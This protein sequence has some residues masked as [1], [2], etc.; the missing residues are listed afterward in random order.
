MAQ[1]RCFRLLAALACCALLCACGESLQ[2]SLWPGGLWPG[3]LLPS[4]NV[5]ELL[6]APRQSEQQNAVQTALNNYLGESLQ[7]KYPRGG[8]EPDPVIFADLD[9][10]GAGEAAV[11]YTAPSKGQNVHL[12]VLE[13]GEDGWSVAYEVM[14]L[15]S[16]VAEV[17]RVQLFDGSV[18]L[19]VGYANANL[20][21]KYLEIYDY[22]D[23]TIYSA[24]RQPYDAY[25]IGALT[26]E[27]LQLAVACTTA[28]P[29]ASVLQLFAAD[30]RSMAL[31]QTEELDARI[32]RCTGIYPTVCGAAHGLIV[33]GATAQGS[34]A[35]FFRWEDGL[36]RPCTDG[37]EERAVLLSQRP[38]ALSALTPR[39]L[40]GTNET[41]AAE[42]GASIPTIRAARRFYP[43]DW[44][45]HLSEKPLRRYGIYDTQYNYFLRLPEAWRSRIFLSAQSDTDWQIRNA[46]DGRLLCMVRI[47]DRFATDGMYIE[48]AQ[49]PEHKLLLYFSEACPPAYI[50]L[51][52]N[53]VLVLE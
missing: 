41:L 38:R 47:V 40:V 7:L 5:E 43:V 24:C 6:R 31:Q 33:D 52:R 35:Q 25:R 50:N 22:R 34:A 23:I 37:T 13:S 11:L 17:E 1:K 14:G 29:G 27:G 20:T 32:E 4:G 26:G 51:I 28:E 16:E 18:Q 48:A 12:A 9:G 45:D 3:G 15:S 21:D 10:D 36:F 19:C 49:L 44:V 53:G 8:G 46:E 2:S 30:G 42:A 39:D